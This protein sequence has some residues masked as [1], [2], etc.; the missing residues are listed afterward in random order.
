MCLESKMVE[1]L[2]SI[3]TRGFLPVYD[4]MLA[5]KLLLQANPEM[6]HR[7]TN[8]W[9]LAEDGT[10]EMVSHGVVESIPESNPNDEPL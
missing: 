10:R 4:Q 6:F 5:Q 8:T 2:L 9:D 1:G 7:V 3:I